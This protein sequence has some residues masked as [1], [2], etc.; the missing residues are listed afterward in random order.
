MSQK[1][2]AH[3]DQVKVFF[4][5]I[6]RLQQKNRFISS[7]VWANLSIVQ[8][9]IIL[10]IST[11]MG[12]MSDL[13]DIFKLDQSTISRHISS[14]IAKKYVV[15]KA[16]KED[17]R[18]KILSLTTQG[19]AY[20][21]RYS[22]EANNN[23]ERHTRHLSADE[24]NDLEFFFKSVADKIGSPALKLARSDFP[25]RREMRRL[26]HGLGMMSQSFFDSGITVGAWQ[27]LS[28]IVYHPH[29]N[30]QAIIAKA[31]GTPLPTVASIV[32]R[33][34]SERLVKLTEAKHDARITT[35]EVTTKGREKVQSIENAYIELLSIGAAEISPKDLARY[36][37]ILEK[38]IGESASGGIFLDEQYILNV[39]TNASDLNTLRSLTVK[40]LATGEPPLTLPSLLFHEGSICWNIMRNHSTVA[41][42]EF[43][44]HDSRM[45]C[46][47]LVFLSHTKLSEKRTI[48]E[49]VSRFF[50][51]EDSNDQQL[52]TFENSYILTDDLPLRT[53]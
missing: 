46:N 8:C 30:S 32:T 2:Y 1:N 3:K 31:F 53:L 43:T 45:V 36:L 34:S 19:E 24:I 49:M 25:I 12:R 37:S 17:G 40:Y 16:H 13:I 35:I 18:S 21:D 33:L 42:G 51:P 27:V 26:T 7:D 29:R 15:A 10:E 5:L 41:I 28:E 52:Y 23:Y 48:L 44:F 38:Y 50:M 47:N 39:I 22:I 11:G 14:L 6:R 4:T 9:M 20:L